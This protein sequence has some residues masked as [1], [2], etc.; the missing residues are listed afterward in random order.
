[1][2]T[3]KMIP[4]RLVSDTDEKLLKPTDMVD[5]L[6]ITVSEDGE[7]TGGVIKNAR[8]NAPV[9]FDSDTDTIQYAM[10]SLVPGSRVIGQVADPARG[11]IYFFV[12]GGASDTNREDDG[13]YRYSKDDDQ[14]TLVYKNPILDFSEETNIT[15]NIVNGQ[16]SQSDDLE[17]MLYFTGDSMLHPPRKINVDRAIDGRYYF[18]T[19]LSSGAEDV[20][21]TVAR[22][23]ITLCPT[24]TFETDLDL[25]TNNFVK[26]TF[27]FA[28]QL[29]YEDGEV[30]AISPYSK[31]SYP[32][33]IASS[34]LEDDG[35]GLLPITDNVCV[36]DTRYVRS[37]S[38]DRFLP[39]VK[40]LRILGRDGNAEEMFVV[41]EFNPR[42]SITRK[43]FG[44][45]KEVYSS[46]TGIY[47]FYN[48][49]AYRSV[50][51]E[52]VLKMYDNVPKTA[53]GQTIA[54]NRL[55][56][57]HY[58]E[59][60]DNV[61]ATATL[62]PVYVDANSDSEIIGE[63]EATSIITAHNAYA[64][65]DIDLLSA[66]D[67]TSTAQEVEDGTTLSL[68]FTLQ[69]PNTLSLVSNSASWGLFYGWIQSTGV[70]DYGGR[71]AS[72]GDDPIVVSNNNN[73]NITVEVNV[74]TPIAETV[75]DV[76]DKIVEKIEQQNIFQ[77]FTYSVTSANPAKFIVD[78]I[79][80]G[81][82][83]PSFTAGDEVDFVG[84]LDIGWS[85]EVERTA[86]TI[87]VFP[88]ARKVES[89]TQAASLTVMNP[90]SQQVNGST[91][92]SGRIFTASD[93]GS[94]FVAAADA[95]GARVNP[96]N[97]PFENTAD[98]TGALY[99]NI[100][101]G[102][103]GE[104][105]GPTDRKISMV[106]FSATPSFKSGSSHELGVVY[107]D[108]FNRSGFVNKLG[109]FYA[110]RPQ[111]RA[112]GEG[113]AG[114]L[115]EAAITSDAPS[116]AKTFQFVYPG[117][118]S[119]SSVFTYTT[120][121]ARTAYNKQ[122][123]DSASSPNVASHFKADENNK[124]VYVNIDTIENF[125]DKKG[126]VIDYSFTPGDI[127]RIVSREDTSGTTY[128]PS[129]ASGGAIEFRVVDDVTLGDTDN[130]LYPTISNEVPAKYKGRWL[131][132]DAP[133]VAAGLAYNT[134]GDE[135]K[136]QYF[137]WFSVTNAFFNGTNSVDFTGTYPDG[138]T[139]VTD[140]RWGH[141][142]VIEILTPRGGASDRIW[143]EIGEAHDIDDHADTFTLVG[144]VYQRS[145]A[146]NGP[147]YDGSFWTTGQASES[148]GFST[149][150]IE[151]PYISDYILESSKAWSR[152][153][154]HVQAENEGERFY[155]SSITYSDEYQDDIT[156]LRLSSFNPTKA[157]FFNF[158]KKY[159]SLYSIQD[160]NDRL[161]GLQQNR[162]SFTTVNKNLLSYAD[163]SGS[164]SVS[165]N[166]FGSTLYAEVD[167][168]LSDP[169]I[170]SVLN[171]GGS[172]Y[173]A[174]YDREKI[175]KVSGNGLSFIS[176]LGLR[177]EFEDEFRAYKNASE[178]INIVS[179]YDPRD[180]VVFFTFEYSPSSKTYGYTE[181][182]G[183]WTSRFSFIP[184]RYAYIDNTMFTFKFDQTLAYT[185]DIIIWKHTDSADRCKYYDEQYDSSVTVVSNQTP[186]NV[187]VFDAMS[188]ETD[189]DSWS[190]PSG[191]VTTEL[192]CSGRVRSF[193]DKEGVRYSAFGRDE[194]TNIASAIPL[195]ELAEILPVNI[196]SPVTMASKL[197]R[198]PIKTGMGIRKLVGGE[199]EH[200]ASTS[201]SP[202]ISSWSGTTLT[203]NTFFGD[204]LTP[205]G[206]PL[207]AVL[208]ENEVNGGP[209][210]G[211]WAK[212]KLDN[213]ST[214]KYELYSIN[215]YTSDSPYHYG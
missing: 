77:T 84:S 48:D 24:T 16:F 25:D 214:T 196:S 98:G 21:L 56:Y 213:N 6:N 23:P 140:S 161:L 64:G 36:I 37:E 143:Y 17:T 3:N 79:P 127:L 55:V 138:T 26:T 87:R 128:F 195:G 113:K 92:A 66:T 129:A 156:D 199:L 200:I 5:A 46:S 164:V 43:V 149:I 167:A 135:E 206:T 201:L 83:N 126:A 130:P 99:A 4:R 134:S 102:L 29:V 22:P 103:S 209:I 69:I 188:L 215:T 121:T 110:E 78:Y 189:S 168:G 68:S 165:E 124:R 151:T 144:D 58:K 163:G 136:Y 70:Y 71:I 131:V 197:D 51:A 86:N 122:T 119:Y 154:S 65:V 194:A 54:G 96:D 52:D 203:L 186:S 175:V 63:N 57:S 148:W 146:C 18:R 153:R 10:P 145:V 173:F 97:I 27:Q 41:D 178:K 141:R 160:Y 90:G 183:F 91:V 109:S 88:V 50:P 157:N 185:Q 67:L 182:T 117:A 111:E 180:G 115:C 202:T 162:V 204:T 49:S 181:S 176:D 47:R 82:A 170:G 212:I 35:D 11:F 62:T 107:F 120:G 105:G 2:A 45:D 44:N 1:M 137:D 15:A 125:K 112:G 150:S 123:W 9:F 177:S 166:P 100:T 74:A 61:D 139:P 210:R 106:S 95:A 8:G 59:G 40:L 104:S 190:S 31:L 198:L 19:S 34:G 94:S 85:I 53:M 191:G 75:D 207:Y 93:A 187:K 133:S 169:F 7:G 118:G 28:T 20:L 33:N 72:S 114:V 132:L 32:D 38:N 39:H 159:G 13:I 30:S 147:E 179:G 76:I 80:S 192:G 208:D 42:Q 142:T 60:Y 171:N 152:G 174:D 89:S 12:K 172:V 101:T 155:R 184:S 158:D 14:Y 211:A 205:S 116:W 81:I 193:T 73:D 108:E